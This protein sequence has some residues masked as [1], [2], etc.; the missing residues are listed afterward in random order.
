ME[1]REAKLAAP[2]GFELPDLNGGEAGF[3][4][5]PE[6]ERRYTTTYWDTPDLRLARWQASLRYR[7]DEGW[8]V[9]LPVATDGPVVVRQEL[10]FQG[11]PGKVPDEA[12]GLVRAF[13]R[14]AQLAPVAR[15]RA[16]RRRVALRNAAGEEL[17]EVVDDQVQVIDGR[18]V[19]GRFRELEV[20][21]TGHARPDTMDRVLARLREAGA[22]ETQGTSKYQRA[23]G[24]REVGPPELVPGELPA[25]PS[26]EELLR[27]DLTASA[28]RF[29]HHEAG[30]RIGEDPEAVHQAR[31][32]SRRV[33]S[34]L[35]TFRG[36]LEPDWTNRLRDEL[37]W[38]AGLLGE[39]RDADVLRARLEE[40]LATQR[41]ADRAAGRQLLARLS[42]ERE[43]ARARLIG[44]MGEERYTALLDDLVAA[45]LAPA[46]LA[47][48][49]RP[50]AELLPPQVASAWSKLRKAVRRA[51]DDPSDEALHKIRIRAKRL[52]YAA[53]AVA[54]AVGKPAE[55]LAKG[56]EGLQEVLGDQ[57]DAVVA[58][59]WL[60]QAAGDRGPRDRALVAGELIALQQAA[61]ANQR[62]RWRKAWKASKGKR[63]TGW[64]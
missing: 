49:A 12:A 52:R 7:D 18:R 56:A 51:G 53:E 34:T 29:L 48:A 8:T 64:F 38:L 20:E 16:V 24:D 33:R 54:P 1:E 21:L 59:A 39:V 5:E 61:A 35:R 23:L 27:H 44:A 57:H 11:K 58:E 15:L 13:V 63:V 36:V 10:T 41:E 19:A 46:V 32:A 9:K 22:E 30:V 6:P 17:A 55:R 28:L 4:A 3:L 42:G 62:S 25:D 50:A 45:A 31:V 43:E 37:K 47:E 40:G 60:R 2:A 26:A 14:G